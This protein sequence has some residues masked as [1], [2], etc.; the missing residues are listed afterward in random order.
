MPSSHAAII[1]GFMMARSRRRSIVL[2]IS[3]VSEPGA[4][5]VW[6]T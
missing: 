3:L 5:A 4:A 1:A 6:Y 2:N